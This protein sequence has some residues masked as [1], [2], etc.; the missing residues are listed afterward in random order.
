MTQDF[1]TTHTPLCT[2]CR[3]SNSHITTFSKISTSHTLGTTRVEWV[4]CL[5]TPEWPTHNITWDNI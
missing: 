2:I 1:V 5:V 4:Q 3:M